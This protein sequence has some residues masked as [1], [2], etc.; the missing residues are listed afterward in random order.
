MQSTRIRSLEVRPDCGRE[1]WDL[2]QPRMPDE[3][4]QDRTLAIALRTHEPGQGV[5]ATERTISSPAHR[6]QDELSDGYRGAPHV[7]CRRQG[8]AA[9]IYVERSRVILLFLVRA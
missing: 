2:P 8:D 5:V 4:K 6:G 9:Y 3:P 7:E 1:V